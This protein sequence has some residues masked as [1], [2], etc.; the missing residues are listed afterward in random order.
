M[1]DAAEPAT[2]PAGDDLRADIRA[3]IEAARAAPEPEADPAPEPDA[4]AEG[5]RGRDDKGRFASREAEAPVEEP[6]AGKPEPASAKQPERL[7]A[8]SGWPADAK[9]DWNRLP[10]ALQTSILEDVQANRL[11]FGGEASGS[12]EADPIVQAARAYEADAQAV[13]VTPAEYVKNTLAWARELARDPH[14]YLPQ[15]ARTL[16]IDLAQTVAARQGDAAGVSTG[17]PEIMQLRQQVQ[18][19]QAMLTKT[20]QAEVERRLS[21][22]NE[23]IAAWKDEKD[24]SGN[25]LRPYYSEIP[26]AALAMRVQLIRAE[27]PNLPIR[28]V[29]QRAYDAET[30]AHPEIRSRE[31]ARIT[32]AKA[33]S[34]EDA[35]AAEAAKARRVSVTDN[36]APMSV[37]AEDMTLR[38][39]IR[40]AMAAASRV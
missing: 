3:A 39:T 15:L 37:G 36:R 19:M 32:A 14:T 16:G 27:N 30:F 33:K 22:I 29:L 10:K 28:E 13:N 35:K 11:R 17:S 34:T 24:G 40:Q 12:V 25:A 21:G 18:E 8:P 38:D 6:E 2:E 26:E 9:T 7:E 1:L 23:E 4:P 5:P 20:Q 31:L